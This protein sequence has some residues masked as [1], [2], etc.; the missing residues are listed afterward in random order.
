MDLED[1]FKNCAPC[2]LPHID[3]IANPNLIMIS[4][5]L[6]CM[7]CN[8]AHG[9]ATMILHDVCLI[10][11]HMRCLTSPLDQIP[12]GQWICS[13]CQKIYEHS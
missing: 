9:A 11:W 4:T 10:D 6:K 7:L 13:W 8:R 12:T 3:G 1:H 5:N 2:H